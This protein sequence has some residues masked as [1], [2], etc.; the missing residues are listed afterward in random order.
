MVWGW[1]T[2][3]KL[4]FLPAEFFAEAK[5]FCREK[6][7]LGNFSC[8]LCVKCL[9]AQERLYDNIHISWL[10]LSRA[11]IG[12]FRSKTEVKRNKSSCR[13]V[14][15][16]GLSTLFFTFE[17]CVDFS[18]IFLP[19]FKAVQRF[20]RNFFQRVMDDDDRRKT[21]F[22][23]SCSEYS[24]LI[25]RVVTMEY[26]TSDR[27]SACACISS[28][29]A[30]RELSAAV[31]RQANS[32][33]F[34]CASWA[35]NFCAWPCHCNPTFLLKRRSSCSNNHS[36]TWS[37]L[38]E[39]SRL[40]TRCGKVGVQSQHRRSNSRVTV[41]IEANRNAHNEWY[42][43]F[44]FFETLFYKLPFPLP[45]WSRE[46]LVKNLQVVGGQ[47]RKPPVHFRRDCIGRSTSIQCV[48]LQPSM[49]SDLGNG[50]FWVEIRD[51]NLVDRSTHK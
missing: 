8:F 7:L 6:I 9:S 11:V 23:A 51:A 43:L 32:S 19:S 30:L 5:C 1:Y 28:E 17:R 48:Q 35:S 33:I 49:N 36:V 15:Y 38:F 39:E 3:Q 21:F 31:V 42:E 40:S 25:Y 14:F 41:P 37:F 2:F 27:G 16:L 18:K 50:S 4:S 22:L 20:W 26:R 12:I 47:L 13:G 34:H 24:S 29:S 44:S 10:M 45:W 46:F